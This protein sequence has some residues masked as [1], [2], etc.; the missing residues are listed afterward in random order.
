M[1]AQLVAGSKYVAD[2]FHNMLILK[3]D[4]RGV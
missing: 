4:S 3:Y 2:R 1:L